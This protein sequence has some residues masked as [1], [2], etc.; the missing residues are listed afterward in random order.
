MGGRV[1]MP[2]QRS[3]VTLIDIARDAGVS[4]STVSLVLQGSALVRPETADKVQS[5]IRKLGYVYNR[6][7][8]NLRRARSNIVGGVIN[9]LTNPFFA[10]LAVGIERVFRV[11]GYDPFI[12]T[13]EV[14]ALLQ[15]EVLQAM[16]EHVVAGIIASPAR[17]TRTDAFDGFLKAGVPVV[18]AMRGL[19]GSRA[20]SV[21][22]QNERGA[23]DA[24]RHLIGLGHRRIA[25][26]GGYPD[27]VVQQQ[28][29]S[30]YRTALQQAG[31]PFDPT[32]VIE[33]DLSRD[34]GIRAF[35]RLQ[36]MAAPP[37][38]A[39]CFNDIVA[40][41]VMLALKRLGREAGTDFAV[42]GF[43]DVAEAGLYTPALTTV[44]VDAQG[45][46]ERAAQAMLKMIETGRIHGED[47]SGAVQL[48]VRESC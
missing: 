33:A 27:M 22:P 44:K 40:F 38:A 5:S 4:K 37:S 43:D 30:G 1:C 45:I 14:S 46:G 41:G 16:R 21:T 6:G 28:R 17:G 3:T 2:A 10:E 26:L 29:V 11:A 20:T 7:A 9:D 31:I 39:L 47:Q 42:V 8:A 24:V 15:A 36:P 32:L 23:S 25:F 19:P 18:H 12:A 35:E 48:V 13:T 34:G